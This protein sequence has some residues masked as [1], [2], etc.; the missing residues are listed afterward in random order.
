MAVK[1]SFAVL[2]YALALPACSTEDEGSGA[3]EVRETGGD[4]VTGTDLQCSAHDAEVLT[5]CYEGVTPVRGTGSWSAAPGVINVVL[6]R[7]SNASDDTA[8]QLVIELTFAAG[9]GLTASAK[10]E[11]LSFPPS[12]PPQRATG[13]WIQPSETADSLEGRNAGRFSIDFDWGTAS[14][15]YDTADRA[16]SA[17]AATARG[18]G[19]R[20]KFVENLPAIPR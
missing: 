10:Q 4:A 2:L 3:I 1:T 20:A 6:G 15:T 18:G 13:G 17:V 11:I 14:G 5:P 16:T 7:S 9:G 19:R 12:G 8:V